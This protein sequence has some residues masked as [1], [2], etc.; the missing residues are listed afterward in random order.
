MEK[1]KTMWEKPTS[2]RKRFKILLWGPP[3]CFKTRTIL[4]LGH[5]DGGADP[6]MAIA[7]LEFGTDHY[8]EEFN[9]LRSQTIDPDEIL[10]NVKSL[11]KSPGPIRV[12]GF[13]GFSIYYEALVNKYAELF[14]KREIRS[15]GHKGEYY[16]LQPR[17][18]QPINRD[19]YELVRLLL[20]CD[21]HVLASCQSKDKWGADMKVIGKMPDGPKR[22]PHYFDT[23]IEIAEGKKEGT[24]KAFIRGKDR[25]GH[26]Q[27]GEEIPW[28]SDEKAAAYLVEKFGQ[29][30]VTSPEAEPFKEVKTSSKKA[31]PK[32]KGTNEK[33][34][35]IEK[36][37]DGVS[38][39]Q[40]QKPSLA[41]PKKEA[42]SEQKLDPQNLLMDVVKLKKELKITDKKVWDA[43]L[44]PFDVATAKDMS[45]DQLTSFIGELQSMR[46]TQAQ[47]A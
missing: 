36:V 5:K 16:T 41:E 3:G 7:D 20:K 11:V 30:L 42:I 23:V 4:R 6:V 26:F 24:W 33:E 18:Y 21:M 35:S 25:S 45:T 19:A 14:L 15:A 17:D 46:P 1:I 2:Q 38:T 32:T 22:I 29:D 44:V 34:P 9:F 13:D 37:K 10:N 31:K 8:A 12:I 27:P 39:A 43:L 40:V 47:A 28:E